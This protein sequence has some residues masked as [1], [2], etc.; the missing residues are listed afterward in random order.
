MT[1]QVKIQLRG[2]TKP[3]V[4]RRLLVPADCTFHNLHH[5]IQMSFG[6]FN[7]HLYKFMKKPYDGG[8]TIKELDDEDYL[9]D[10]SEFFPDRPKPIDSKSITIGEFLKENP[11]DKFTYIYDFG[12]DWIHDITIEGE[13]EDILIHPRCTAGKG[14][15]PPEDC[16]G[17]WGYENMKCV[18][19]EAPRSEDA[20]MYRKWLGLG[21]GKKF[22]PNLFDLDDANRRIVEMIEYIREDSNQNT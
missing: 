20:R 9:N 14:A 19:L 18:L 10:F 12:D 7:M 5:V 6:W 16:G 22:D 8:W 2:I 21:R 13:T 15:C 3:P 17:M 1:Y 4:W 11:I